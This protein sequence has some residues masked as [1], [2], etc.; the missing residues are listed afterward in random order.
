MGATVNGP[1]SQSIHRQ[2]EPHRIRCK[3][4]LREIVTLKIHHLDCGTMHPILPRLTHGAVPLNQRHL[5]CHCLLIETAAQG[6][7]LVDSGYGTQDVAAP[8]ERL[9]R[10]FL[11]IARPTLDPR[12]TAVAH[13]RALG[14]QPSDV[15]HIVLT[16]LDIDHA[17][18]LPDF[19]QARVHVM[20]AE[21]EA[22]RHA[23]GRHALRYRPAQWAHGPNWC[24]HREQG[25]RWFGFDAVRE[26]PGLPPELL[27]VPLA[28]HSPGHAGVAIDTQAGWLLHGGDA[29]FHRGVVDPGV[30]SPTMGLGLFE[31]FTQWRSDLRAQNQ[32]HLRELA[33]EKSNKINMFCAHDAVEF[34][35]FQDRLQIGSLS[36]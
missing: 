5:V 8:R 31:R 28:G 34:Q 22:T 30:A 6:L 24:L 9:G 1:A 36:G 2:A 26:L 13:I 33:A 27:L 18:G 11:S 17:G 21:L 23:R 12:A 14:H 20:A 3:A 29:W 7:V 35:R 16:H 15:R 32:A 10:M 25:G 19:P 4:V